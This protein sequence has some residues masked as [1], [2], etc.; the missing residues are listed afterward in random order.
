M[1]MP[2]TRYAR[3]GDVAIAYQVVGE[4][5]FDLVFVPEFSNLIWYWQHPLPAGFLR[6]V[7]SFSRLILLDKRGMGLSDRPR[8]LGSLETRMDDIRAVLDAAGS[9]RA[10]LFGMYSMGRLCLLFA[11]TYPERTEA[12]VTVG[13]LAR[14]ESREDNAARLREVRARWGDWDYHATFVKE[15]S[16]RDYVA[17]WVNLCR[18]S[19]SPAA[20][21]DYIRMDQETDVTDI[22]SAVHVPALVFYESVGDSSWEVGQYLPNAEMVAVP[23]DEWGSPW[24]MPRLLPE[25]RRFLVDHDRGVIPDSV[26]ATLL[27]TDIVASTERTAALGDRAWRDLLAEHHRAARQHISRYRGRE[28]DTAGD[29]VFASFD[30]PARAIRCAQEIVAAASDSG[31]EI[32]AGVHTGECE[33]L[34][35]KL[36]GLAVSAGA[37]IAAA[38]NGG[39]ILVSGTVKDLVAGSGLTFQ[40]RGLHKLKGVG[41]W[42][43][44]AALT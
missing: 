24:H 33:I 44:Y 22:V 6:E 43:L 23:A 27:F 19:A 21:A 37:R 15:A 42:P 35:D 4:G 20:A 41:E 17:W 34:G 13:T 8:S 11:A 40:Q 28:L 5:P 38:A 12:L 36:A 14:P 2:E 26:L 25:L 1:D 9:E 30:G 39:E 31:L 29:G 3:S 7:A 16:A 32:R 18:L 10:V